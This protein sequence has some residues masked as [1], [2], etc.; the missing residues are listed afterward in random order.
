M[1]NSKRIPT[2][3]KAVAWQEFEEGIVILQSRASLAHEL[4]GSAAQ[5]WLNITGEKSIEQINQQVCEEYGLGPDETLSD[6]AEFVSELVD[7]GLCQWL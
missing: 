3:T 4:N 7:Q 6:T 2:K 1:E 5:I